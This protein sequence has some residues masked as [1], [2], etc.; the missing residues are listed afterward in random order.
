LDDNQDIASMIISGDITWKRE[1]H[2]FKL[3]EDFL[4][5]ICSVGG[6]DK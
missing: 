4:S 2:E 5:S 6:L 1:E 3:A